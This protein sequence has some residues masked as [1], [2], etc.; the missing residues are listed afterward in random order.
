MTRSRRLQR[1]ASCVRSIRPATTEFDPDDDEWLLLFE[2]AYHLGQ[3]AH[4]PDFPVALAFYRSALEAA[5]RQTDPPF[6]PPPGHLR[7]HPLRRRQRDWRNQ[8]RFPD[9]WA[10]FD[11]LGELATRSAHGI[12]PVTEAEYHELASWLIAHAER[13]QA[14][15]GSSGGIPLADGRF[16]T[17]SGLLH[18][19]SKGP[20]VD[21]AGNVAETI[22]QVK[23]WDAAQ[24]G[25]PR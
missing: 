8:F 9:V 19:I 14:R 10:G 15:T 23:A 20:R 18:D 5:H 3:F 12:P 16:E 2:N 1:I 24:R 6:D 21:G 11:W 17:V 22:R 25:I 4:E 13:L 7:G